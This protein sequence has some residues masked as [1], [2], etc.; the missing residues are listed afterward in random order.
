MEEKLSGSSDGR[1]GKKRKIPTHH[2]QACRCGGGSGGMNTCDV[3]FAGFQ[4]GKPYCFLVWL[5]FGL[6]LAGFSVLF[7]YFASLILSLL[8]CKIMS[9]S[10]YRIFHSCLKAVNFLEGKEK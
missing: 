4:G 5:Y 6:R 7:G 1:R 3:F 2:D 8:F 10:T 9:I